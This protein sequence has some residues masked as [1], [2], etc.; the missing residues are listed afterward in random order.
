MDDRNDRWNNAGLSP[1][2]GIEENTNLLVL[3]GIKNLAVTTGIEYDEAGIRAAMLTSNRKGTVNIEA[4]EEVTG[5]FTTQEKLVKGIKEIRDRLPSG[6]KESFVSCLPG[7]EIY[8]AQIAFRNLPPS[9][10]ETALRLELRKYLPF[11]ADKAEIDFQILKHSKK[12]KKDVSLLVTA[13]DKNLL[14]NH[15]QC[16]SSAG[17]KPGIV[18]ILPLATANA[19]WAAH[20]SLK[21]EKP[22]V[23]MHVGAEKCTLVIDGDNHPFFFRNIYF[24]K[25]SA[26]TASGVKPGGE[27]N[28]NPEGLSDEIVRSLAFYVGTHNAAGFTGIYLTGGLMQDGVKKLIST[29]TGLEVRQLQL[30]EKCGRTV[31]DGS[32]KFDICI[33]LALRGS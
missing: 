4:L 29:K 33:A 16:L 10:M 15:L 32:G 13:A 12:D 22:H 1:A 28:A 9:E 7:K 20:P 30:C 17:I 14:D 31:T 25:W 11:E 19:F 18:D 6:V 5:D 21:E 23:V 27:V 24:N 26:D 8:A 3:P 2:P